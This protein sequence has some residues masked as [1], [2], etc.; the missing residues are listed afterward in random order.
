MDGSQPGSFVH[1][2]LQARTLEWVAITFSKGFSWPRDQTRISCISGRFLTD[3]VTREPLL[4]RE[5]TWSEVTQSCL[6][7]CVPMDCSLQSMGSSVHGIFQAR[8]LEWVAISFSRG[9]S[10][11]RDQTQ[12]SKSPLERRGYRLLPD[13]LNLNIKWYFIEKYPLLQ[14]K[15]G[16]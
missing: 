5:V 15:E 6:T 14:A 13:D 7:F 12:I 1:G 9:S 3:W 2:I 16:I 11:S 10:Q 4:R 8:I